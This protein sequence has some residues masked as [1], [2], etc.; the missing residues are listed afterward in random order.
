MQDLLA[1]IIWT[2]LGKK[3]NPVLFF[4]SHKIMWKICLNTEFIFKMHLNHPDYQMFSKF[5]DRIVWIFC[6]YLSSLRILLEY[7][8]I[9]SIYCFFVWAPSQICQVHSNVEFTVNMDGYCK[10]ARTPTRLN[11]HNCIVTNI[12]I[13]IIT[14]FSL[15]FI[16]FCYD[17]LVTLLKMTQVFYSFCV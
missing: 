14:F 16:C 4:C 7:I 6:I 12:F 11:Q 9:C 8:F 10:I 2:I 13:L 1:M 5:M 17:N 3:F 15:S